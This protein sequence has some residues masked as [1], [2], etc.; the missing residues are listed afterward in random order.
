[1]EG[2]NCRRGRPW[3]WVAAA[4][5]GL[6]L[7]AVVAQ[8]AEAGRFRGRGWGRGWGYR[9]YR[10]PARAYYRAYPRYGYGYRGYGYGYRG[11]APGY[12][13]GGGYP[14]GYGYGG[15]YA[16]MRPGIGYFNYVPP[17]L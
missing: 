6:S 12:Y 10:M 11:A 14:H 9:A 3:K 4:L 16:P 5:L 2:N 7:F 15:Y 8:P 17:M 1:M 13:Y